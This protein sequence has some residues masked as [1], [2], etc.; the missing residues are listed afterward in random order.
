MN[1]DKS[2]SKQ[3]KFTDKKPNIK[4]N[5]ITKDNYIFIS[6]H[7][8][9][10]I[11]GNIYSIP[12]NYEHIGNHIYINH[13]KSSV[14]KLINVINL[15]TF[16]NK[17]YE[18]NIIGDNYIKCSI[19]NTNILD[20]KNNTYIY[21]LYDRIYMRD[22]GHILIMSNNCKKI[23]NNNFICYNPVMKICSNIIFNVNEENDNMYNVS[24]FISRNNITKLKYVLL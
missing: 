5:I 8:Y 2:K 24:N 13:N 22:T 9:V 3:D 17:K 19:K 15:N 12:G 11:K 10:T 18:K 21:K 23:A 6:S 16:I 7:I 20:S 14:I 1:D 4:Y